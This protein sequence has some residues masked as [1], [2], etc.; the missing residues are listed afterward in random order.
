MGEAVMGYLIVGVV[1]ILIGHHWGRASVTRD[2]RNAAGFL[3][4][5]F[6]VKK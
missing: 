4:T 3:A 1:G 6:G 2:A 5:L